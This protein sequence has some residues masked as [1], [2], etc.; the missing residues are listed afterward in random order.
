[1]GIAT[2]K[3]GRELFLSGV[4]NLNRKAMPEIGDNLS[5]PKENGE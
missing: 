5:L 3:K 4:G 1:L 2:G